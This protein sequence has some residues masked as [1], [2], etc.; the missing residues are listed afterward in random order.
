MRR[1]ASGLGIVVVLLAGSVGQTAAAGVRLPRPVRSV[2]AR[3]VLHTD[4]AIAEGERQI[5]AAV[6]DKRSRTGVEHKLSADLLTR[7][8]AA[9]ATAA[10]SLP[11]DRTDADLVTVDVT[12]TVDGT[13]DAGLARVG[14]RL[15]GRYPQY[16]SVR[17]ELP[18][19]RLDDLASL[20]GVRRVL[21]AQVPDHQSDIALPR[22]V[23]LLKSGTAGSEGESAHLVGPD[24]NPLAARVAF[25]VDGTGVKTCVLSDGVDGLAA[26]KLA[27][28]VPAAVDVLAGQAGT[29]SEGLAMLELIHDLAPGAPLG[30]ATGFEGAASMA[31]NILLLA[32]A[33]CRVIV[34]DLTYALESA[35]QD[36]IISQSVNAVTA[37]GVVYLSSAGNSGNAAGGTSGTWEGDFVAGPSN[38][39]GTFHDFVPADPNRLFDRVQN[40]TGRVLTLSWPNPIGGA[41]SDYDLYVLDIAGN[42]IARSTDTQSMTHEPIEA[43][44]VP[45]GAYAIAVTLFEGPAT[46]F[47]LRLAR[48]N[49]EFAT[50]G[51]TF[52]HNAAL[53]TVSVGATPAA[54]AQQGGGPAGPAA[55]QP[56]TSRN[57]PELFSSDGPRRV[58]FSPTGTPYTPGN[59]S[60]AGGVALHKPDVLAAD[61]TSTSLPQFT[62][63]FGTSAAAP[64]AAAITAL[65]RQLRPAATRDQVVGALRTG[66]IDLDSPGYNPDTGYGILMANPALQALVDATAA[67]VV[68]V[69]KVPDFVP[70]APQ[71]V[72]ETRSDVGG[73][74][75]YTGPKPGAGQVI[76]LQIVG[77]GSPPIP[78]DA[79]AVA[80]NVTGTG[81]AANGF[82]TVYPCGAGRPTASNLN[83]TTNDTRANMV[84]SKIGDGGRVCLF[85]LNP[86]NLIADIAGY[87]P[88]GSP[89]Q[90]VVPE[91]LLETRAAGQTG[92]T[93]AKPAPGQTIELQVTGAGATKVPPDAEAV[94][95][96]V[97]A[98][99]ATNAGFV[100]VYPCG[101][102]RP[103]SSNLNLAIGV[104]AA[105][106]V[107]SKIGVGG[108]VCL[109]TQWGGHLL[110]DV[111]GYHPAGASYEAIDPVRVL[112]T[113]LGVG[114]AGP[115]SV[116]RVVPLTLR[117]TNGVPA[118]ATS[119]V[120]NVT[121]TD[122]AADG[123]V[124]VW[125]CA[126]AR[127]TA[128]NVNVPRNDTRPNL[129]FA[130]VDAAGQ[131]CLFTQQPMALVADLV[132]WYP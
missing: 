49:L 81:V 120:L 69:P 51:A 64:H 76:E 66:S 103:N 100:T 73:Q 93:G 24:T 67:P 110:A 27:N 7:R 41:T 114:A 52:G 77:A 65:L 80:L 38:T 68:P 83:L 37:R 11:A 19:M 62:P 75:G 21:P 87:M 63:F 44:T 116:G 50:T 56:F 107:V 55:G 122:V 91:R 96:N 104:T 129:V 42:V 28:E 1:G 39:A 124:T 95:L 118:T 2:I 82:V 119:V 94:V 117:G 30:F 70:L 121:A 74:V 79:I 113:R 84:V 16:D 26:S 10:R 6:A 57:R 115:P 59:S 90:P 86:T 15:V 54:A 8:E 111:A 53:N 61:G 29:G 34:D 97:T 25:N 72:L 105:N 126:E 106:L 20:P 125:P 5:A 12:A 88:G 33:G 31:Q 60:G 130:K 92:Y 4:A 99:E 9:A 48:G 58:Y 127:P 3:P 36:D 89:Y 35:F 23:R 131:V 45:G 22:G 13:L 78:G 132:G 101:I 40:A 71:R 32:D 123:F 112:D 43:V 14:A 18:S 46:A 128:S 98:T 17:V 102:A 85:T 108:K 47:R 109:F